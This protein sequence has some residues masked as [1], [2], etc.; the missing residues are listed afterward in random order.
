MNRD[1]MDPDQ[2]TLTRSWFEDSEVK[3]REN[4]DWTVSWGSNQWPSG[5][6]ELNS[7]I[8]IPLV[9]GTYDVTFNTGTLAFDFASNPDACGEIGMVGDFN[10]WG[11][12][13]SDVPADVYLVRDPMYPSQFSLEY[14]FTSSTGLLFRLDADATFQNVWGGV[15]P[16]GAWPCATGVFGDPLA[17][18]DVPGGKYRVTF[19]CQSG[20][21]CFERLGNAVTAPKVFAMT[22]DGNLDEADWDINQPISNVVDGTVVGEKAEA[23]FG[24]TYNEEYLY[25]GIDMYDAAMMG[26]ETGEVFVDGD[27]SGGDYDDFD[28]HI[29]FSAAGVEVLQGPAGLVPLIGFVVSPTFDGFTAEVGIP[30]ADLGVTP[31]EGAQIGFDAMINDDNTG[32]GIEY[33]MAWNG[34]LQNYESTSSF[35]DLLF[36]NLSC[37]CISVYNETIGDVQLRNPTDMPTTYVGTY[38][39]DDMYDLVF[40]KDFA[41]TVAWSAGDWP[42]GIATIGGDPIPGDIGRFRISFDCVTGEYSFTVIP[43]EGVA[44]AQW[45]D[46]AVTIDGDLSEFSLDYGSDILAAGTGPINNVVAWG[47]LWDATSFYI[48]A[49]VEDA[50]VEGAGNPWDNDAIE[51]Y[52]DGNHDE[53]GAFDSDF[54]TQLILDFVNES[55][56]WIKAD[57]VPVTDY[58]SNWTFTNDGYNVELR[59]AWSNIDFFAGRNKSIGWSL[60]NNDSDNGIGRDYQSVWY[61][62]ENNWNNTGV[63]GDLQLAGGPYSIGISEH[64]TYD[65]SFVLYPN[66]SNGNTYLRTTGDI[67]DGEVDIYINDLTGRTVTTQNET[68]FGANNI[69]QLNTNQLESGIY[70]ITIVAEDNKKAVKKLILQ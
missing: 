13:G 59:V 46:D 2:W 10:N 24:V 67:F 48:G 33:T 4:N 54:D 20:D 61:G 57:G 37:G 60:G 25:I 43:V 39:L 6:A 19:N 28:C 70:F 52:I 55:V 32:T 40:R 29:K 38:E 56:L 9:A 65:A 44:Y 1:A 8:N 26:T 14:N 18:I 41:E 50:V 31:M 12:D 3:F 36:G 30:W 45:T 53:D 16:T 49:Q 23:Y 5:I 21:F 7:S 22:V 62:D 69:V 34:G 51:F 27:K 42:T 35:G 64:A 17:I 66:P 58:E 15:F 47:A 68:I 63:L 11:D